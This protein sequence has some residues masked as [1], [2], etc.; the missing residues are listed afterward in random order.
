M[1]YQK[2]QWIDNVTP[3][4]A[5]RMN[6]IENGIANATNVGTNNSQ[7]ISN[8]NS[9]ISDIN[10]NIET[11][12]ENIDSLETNVDTKLPKQQGVENAG[13]VLTVGEDGNVTPQDASGGGGGNNPIVSFSYL[14]NTSDVYY[15]E[16]SG[17]EI[18]GEGY[19]SDNLGGHTI[20]S[21]GMSLPIIAGEGISITPNENNNQII[22]SST[23]S[24]GSSGNVIAKT[25]SN[26]DD[27]V[28]DFDSLV[29]AGNYRVVN[30]QIID[31]SLTEN[32]INMKG[33]ATNLSSHEIQTINKNFSF[34]GVGHSYS[35][36]IPQSGIM[37]LYG[38][39]NLT[40]L[41]ESSLYLCTDVVALNYADS[42]DPYVPLHSIQIY[43]TA[44]Y[45]DYDTNNIEHLYGIKRYNFSDFSSITIDVLYAE[46]NL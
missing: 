25:Y 3:L 12:N 36:S 39:Y 28:A 37:H 7:A 4:D 21:A 44:S 29:T 19:Y 8:I 5:S 16:S 13:K 33:T 34:L 46:I 35:G 22:I 38:S 30:I 20:P 11:I 9:S 10:T 23:G 1:T 41:T 27:L 24:G 15:N 14:I 31:F 2:T 43:R 26:W 17:I 32:N 45:I 6:N 42:S 18:T 40:P